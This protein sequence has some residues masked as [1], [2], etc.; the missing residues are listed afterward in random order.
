LIHQPGSGAFLKNTARDMFAPA[1][2]Y[3]YK[4]QSQ[5][6]PGS[7]QSMQS[8]PAYKSIEGT[9]TELSRMR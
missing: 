3:L 7:D 4:A 9:S 2:P 1:L 8:R 6:I 5:Y